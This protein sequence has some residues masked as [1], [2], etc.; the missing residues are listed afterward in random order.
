[1]KKNY[2]DKFGY[3]AAA[4]EAEHQLVSLQNQ[5]VIDYVYTEDSDAVVCGSKAT[6]F[7][8]KGGKCTL[9][10]LEDLFTSVLPIAFNTVNFLP[11]WNGRIMR[12]LACFLGNDYVNRAQGNGPKK[13]ET[14][15]FDLVDNG[16]L[17]TGESYLAVLQK[18]VIKSTDKDPIRK[19]LFSVEMFECA[20]AFMMCPTKDISTREAFWTNEYNIVLSPMNKSNNDNNENFNESSSWMCN[21]D[22]CFESICQTAYLF[23]FDPTILFNNDC[24]TSLFQ[25]KTWNGEVLKSLELPTFNGKETFHG[26]IS[27]NSFVSHCVPKPQI[28][29]ARFL[30]SFLP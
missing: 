21:R 30:F 2:N 1:M 7:N 27:K 3:C 16:I 28:N 22:D 10:N 12:E 4:F 17:K 23:G 9:V 6:I 18:H 13:A 14:F 20:P 19:W 24:F 26:A 29:F 5:G 11:K 25:M 8:C 15:L